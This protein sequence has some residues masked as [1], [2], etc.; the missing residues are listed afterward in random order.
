MPFIWL[1]FSRD[2]KSLYGK[3]KHIRK[4]SLEPVTVGFELGTT[5]LQSCLLSHH[6]MLSVDVVLEFLS[7]LMESWIHLLSADE[8]GEVGGLSCSFLSDLVKFI[9]KYHTREFS[10]QSVEVD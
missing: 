4:V 6:A 5:E 2:H 8:V 1:P 7:V 10:Y 9:G 3:N